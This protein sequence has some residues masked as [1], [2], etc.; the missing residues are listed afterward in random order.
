MLTVTF[1][2]VVVTML[3]LSMKTTRWAG[4]LGIFIALCVAPVLSSLLLILAAIVSYFLLGAPKWDTIRRK[5][6]WRD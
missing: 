4:A 3:L 5:R 1:A 2:F 6:P